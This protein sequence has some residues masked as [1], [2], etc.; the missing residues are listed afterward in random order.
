MV[1]IERDAENRDAAVAAAEKAFWL[2]WCE[3]PPFA[4]HWGLK[5]AK[6]HLGELGAPEPELAPFD[7]AN[8]EP[9]PEVKIDPP[10]D[11]P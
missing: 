9:M 7:E 3:G 2:A 4:Y 10:E 6:E 1:S 8:F 5:A 11:Q